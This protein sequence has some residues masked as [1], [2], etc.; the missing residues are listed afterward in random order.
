V[1]IGRGDVTCTRYSVCFAD[2]RVAQCSKK[3]SHSTIGSPLR[4]K[5]ALAINN[6]QSGPVTRRPNSPPVRRPTSIVTNERPRAPQR[7]AEKPSIIPRVGRRANR[8]VEGP[9][10]VVTTYSLGGSGGA[11]GNDGGA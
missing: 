8:T 11:T 1:P 7:R 5:K 3:G 4:V 2:T 10:I 6:V 9:V